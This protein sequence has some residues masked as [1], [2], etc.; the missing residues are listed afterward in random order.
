MARRALS[1]LG[2]LAAL[3][4]VL[5]VGPASAS[6][7]EA[8]PAPACEAGGAP[9]VF[10]GSVTPADAKTYRDL[11]LEV[12]PGTT[13]VEVGYEWDDVVPLPPIPVVSGLVQTVFDLGLWDEGGVGTVEGFRGWS[14]SRQGKTA[15][16]QDPIWVQADTAE[17]GYRPDPVEPGTWHVDLGVAAVAPAGATYEVTVR[18]RATPVGP[19]FT[20]RPVDPEH[21][22]RDEAGWYAGDLHLHAYHSN[23]KGLA[24]PEMVAAAR[25]AGLDFVPVT[26]YVTNQHWREL[27]PVQEANPDL[28][29]WPGR[30]VITYFGHAI[31]LGETPHEVDWR[32][33]APGVSLRGIE[34]RSVADGALFGV[35]HPTIFPTAAFAAF[36]RGCELTIG[37]TLDWDEVTTLEV[38]TGPLLVDDTALGGPGLGVQIQNPFVLTAMD[39]WQRLLREGHK[40]TAV[41]GSDDKLGPDYGTAVTEVYARQLSRSALA[42]GLRSGHAYVRTRGAVASPTVEVVASAPGGLRGMVGDTLHA[43][44]AALEVHVSGADG[45]TIVVTKDGLP[46]GLVPVVGDDFRTTIP[47][48]RDPGSGPLGTFWRV[49]TTDL[50]GY[51]TIG[52]PVFLSG[53][54]APATTVAPPTTVDPRRPL[55]VT[56]GGG[57]GSAAALALALG[58]SALALTRSARPV[59]V[60]SRPCPDSSSSPNASGTGRRP[61]IRTT[62]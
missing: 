4:S 30:E 20:S 24:G 51:T 41:S 36:C 58:L 49:D 45:Q 42:E 47:A 3:T 7:A 13:R 31:V 10:T 35:A 14:G 22:A 37:D 25:A 5:A 1:A 17:R 9:V 16:G 2:A 26:E 53:A 28:V 11:A 55:P 50:Q 6:K 19:S 39:L 27:G 56:G 48:T 12:R 60:R 59:A 23:P 18:C 44:V 40:I 32:H 8:A 54:A 29:V 57:L 15:E 46:A 52:N 21:V 61:P 34:D 33:G 43:D 38:V 62:R